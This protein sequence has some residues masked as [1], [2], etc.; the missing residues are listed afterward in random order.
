[1]STWLVAEEH[2]IYQVWIAKVFVCNLTIES[3]SLIKIDKSIVT[4]TSRWLERWYLVQNLKGCSFLLSGLRQGGVPDQSVWWIIWS[5]CANRKVVTSR[6][7]PRVFVVDYPS[8]HSWHFP[9]KPVSLSRLE[10]SW[11]P[12]Y[13]GCKP[14]VTPARLPEFPL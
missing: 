1:M 11:M 13:S 10:P 4:Q 14:F 2:N 6:W 7:Y 5:F 3:F 12:S 9:L 8:L